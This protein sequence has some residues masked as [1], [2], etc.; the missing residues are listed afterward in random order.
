[1]EKTEVPFFLICSW[2]TFGIRKSGT[3]GTRA[4]ALPRSGLAGM[5][6]LPDSLIGD[7]EKLPPSA[8]KRDPEFEL[9]GFFVPAGFHK[10]DIEF[11]KCSDLTGSERSR[12]RLLEFDADY[13][14]ALY[15]TDNI[16]ERSR[17]PHRPR[18]EHVGCKGL[19]DHER[20]EFEQAPACADHTITPGGSNGNADLARDRGSVRAGLRHRGICFLL[21]KIIG[22]CACDS[23]KLLYVTSGNVYMDSARVSF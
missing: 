16:A 13:F 20:V 6:H 3:D 23:G 9:H 12:D 15:H 21:V 11:K 5:L 8:G 7:L 1:M 18:G 17:Q 2:I 10:R 19:E 4:G 14:S 22:C